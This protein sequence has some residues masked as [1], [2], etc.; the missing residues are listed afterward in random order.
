MNY[1]P[2]PGGYPAESPTS[3]VD[4]AS[5]RR[6]AVRSKRRGRLNLQPNLI[7]HIF[8]PKIRHPLISDP[9]MI[10]HPSMN[11]PQRDLGAAISPNIVAM[12]RMA[13]EKSNKRSIITKSKI[14]S[15]HN[16]TKGD[17]SSIKMK[18]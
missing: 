11:Y 18:L 3:Y 15:E 5:Q 4:R 16:D 14:R 13:P 10:G 1:H 7:S 6:I 2:E 9:S 17:K 8:E 12:R